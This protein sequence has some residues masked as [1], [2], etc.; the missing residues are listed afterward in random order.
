MARNRK[1]RPIADRQ[2]S[3]Q[4][5]APEAHFTLAG[6]RAAY[7]GGEGEKYRCTMTGDTRKLS[8]RAF[9]DTYAW[10][11]PKG[12]SGWRN[13]TKIEPTASRSQLGILPRSWVALQ[14]QLETA[15]ACQTRLDDQGQRAL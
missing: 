5:R 14:M 4:A 12:A 9:L 6:V 2:R 8:R 3:L 15:E 10:V 7:A 13:V 11:K 1:D